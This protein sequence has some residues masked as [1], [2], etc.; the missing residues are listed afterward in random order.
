VRNYATWVEREGEE[1][2]DR[3]MRLNADGEEEIT[4]K[5]A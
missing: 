5:T 3:W 2:A 4:W 1:T